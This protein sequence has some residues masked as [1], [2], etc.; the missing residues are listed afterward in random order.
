MG[1]VYDLPAVI[2]HITPFFHTEAGQF[3]DLGSRVPKEK[4]IPDWKDD[5][6]AAL[7]WNIRKAIIP[8]SGSRLVVMESVLGYTHS[9]RLSQYANMDMT[10]TANALERTMENSEAFWRKR[11]AG[12]SP[13]CI[14]CGMPGGVPSI[15]DLLM[16]ARS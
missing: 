12:R 14:L 4:L 13:M 3:S 7:L 8:S 1:G 11:R 15:R 9:S 6:A 2:G 10:T 16:S 5:K